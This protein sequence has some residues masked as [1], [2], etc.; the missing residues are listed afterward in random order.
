MEKRRT[1][2]GVL[3]IL[4]FNR[5]FYIAGLGALTILIACHLLN[6]WP[7][8]FLWLIIAGFLYGLITPLIVSAFV[9]DFS[10][11]YKLDWLKNLLRDD[12]RVKLIVSIH[13]GFDETSF[14]IKNKSIDA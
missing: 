9:Y 12:E 10:G 4:S 3:N 11:Y 5:H 14:I 7:N 2:E 13:A 6:G 1:F 8:I